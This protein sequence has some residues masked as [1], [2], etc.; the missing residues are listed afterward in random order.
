[1]LRYDYVLNF[2][3]IFL[4]KFQIQV[5]NSKLTS[6]K[7]PLDIFVNNTSFTIWK[8]KLYVHPAKRDTLFTSK[9]KIKPGSLHTLPE[10]KHIKKSDDHTLLQ[11]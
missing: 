2:F 8:Q 10:T 6:G 7:N 4:P 3:Y 5:I 1:M 9:L 11:N